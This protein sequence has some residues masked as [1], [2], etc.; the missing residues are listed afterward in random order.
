MANKKQCPQCGKYVPEDRTYC[1]N[2]G[3]TLGIRCPECRTVVPVGAKTCTACADHLDE[4]TLRNKCGLQSTVEGLDT[5]LGIKANVGSDHFA[6]LL[7]MDK[8]CHSVEIL[9]HGAAGHS[10]VVADHGKVL[11][12]ALGKS[13]NEFMGISTSHEAAKHYAGAIGNKLNCLFYRYKFRQK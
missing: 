9:A 10:A 2:C 4:R 11:N 6:Y 1:M 13:V 12:T 7:V 8:L 3:I 5:D